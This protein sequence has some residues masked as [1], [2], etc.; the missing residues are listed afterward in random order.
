MTN[1]A[2]N[3]VIIG[4]GGFAKEVYSYLRHDIAINKVKEK[5]AIKGFLDTGRENFINSK[6]PEAYLGDEDSF[7]PKENDYF[8]LAIGNPNIRNKI[9][10][11]LESKKYKFFTYIHSSAFI[12][13]S[14]SIEEGVIICPNCMINAHA[15]IGKHCILNIYSSVAHDCELG[16]YS[17]LSPYSTLNG[18]VRTGSHLFMG[19]HSVILSGIRIGSRC[20]ISAGT[21]VGEHMEDDHSAFLKSRVTYLRKHK[22]L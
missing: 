18:N 15:C 9:I 19:T 4:S 3:I 21:A 16:S 6:I 20:T 11:K 17:I 5:I 2:K 12:A 10:G 14:S 1:S 7:S 13:E 22:E 8:L